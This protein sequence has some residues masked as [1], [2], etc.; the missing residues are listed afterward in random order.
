M[1]QR[2]DNLGDREIGHEK[3]VPPLHSAI[4]LIATQLAQIELEESA[5]VTVDRS[6]QLDP[7]RGSLLAKSPRSASARS[8]PRGPLRWSWRAEDRKPASSGGTPRDLER[9]CR[10]DGRAA[11]ASPQDGHVR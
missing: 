1:R 5:G 4:E 10:V 2:R 7:I 8:D 3:V 9:L 11:R 6:G